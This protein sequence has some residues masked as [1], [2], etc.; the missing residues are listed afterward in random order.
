RKTDACTTP[1]TLHRRTGTTAR[2]PARP[3]SH[4]GPRARTAPA[5]RPQ[6][7]GHPRRVGF[8]EPLPG[9]ARQIPYP[10]REPTPLTSH[11]RGP[12][13][14]NA[15]LTDRARPAQW[16]RPAP[17]Y[18]ARRPASRLS[19]CTEPDRQ[20]YLAPHLD[21][22]LNGLPVD[23]LPAVSP[24]RLDHRFSDPLRVNRDFCHVL[25]RHAP[26][27]HDLVAVGRIPG[28][29]FDKLDTRPPPLPIRT[30]RPAIRVLGLRI[31][32]RALEELRVKMHPDALAHEILRIPPAPPDLIPRDHPQEHGI[33]SAG[34]EIARR[35][36]SLRQNP[37][38]HARLARHHAATVRP[39][40]P[41]HPNE[42]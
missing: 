9:A 24:Q 36:R 17:A 39:R 2:C 13:R 3:D 20:S 29:P 8:R 33:R 38:V 10:F 25:T 22:L 35:G 23:R 15:R 42:P 28:L 34:Q 32:V 31:P 14:A 18:G 11:G 40:R 16:T 1:T 4:A 37:V 6:T 7:S 27:H 5:S 21:E 19:P 26:P 41:Q 30:P 12:Y